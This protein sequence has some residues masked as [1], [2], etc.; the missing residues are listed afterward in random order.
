MNES[1]LHYRN[2]KLESALSSINY[3]VD[4]FPNWADAQYL[5]AL[6][7]AEKDEYEKAGDA[8]QRA[9]EISPKSERLLENIL[10]TMDRGNPQVAI[11]AG[12]RL[13]KMDVADDHLLFHLASAYEANGDYDNAIETADDVLE[14]SREGFSANASK[15]VQARS[16]FELEER[17]ASTEICK[18]LI[19]NHPNTTHEIF[20]H[21]IAGRNLYR[22]H[23]EKA[24]D[25]LDEYLNNQPELDDS[26]RSLRSLRLKNQSNSSSEKPAFA[27]LYKG[28]AKLELGNTSEGLDDLRHAGEQNTDI[29]EYLQKEDFSEYVDSDQVIFNHK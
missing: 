9:M 5:K 24:I 7:H 6:I 13:R 2:K 21:F 17:A 23:P 11:E 28:I 19:D 16:L 12:E 18:E 27:R 22:S 3:A 25:H 29:A 1:L 20:A 8:F 4:K 10:C 26:N 14:I 15:M